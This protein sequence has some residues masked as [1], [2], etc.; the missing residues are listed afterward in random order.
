VILRKPGSQ[1]PAG[2]LMETAY[3]PVFSGMPKPGEAEMLGRLNGAQQIYAS[4]G[5]TTVQEGATHAHDV[6][7]LAKG[8]SQG[9]LYLYVVTLPLFIDVPAMLAKYPAS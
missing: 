8:A 9:L 6:E 2:L 5:Y 4:N 3:L 7:F 1:E